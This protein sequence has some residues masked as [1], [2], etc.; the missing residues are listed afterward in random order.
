[1]RYAPALT[2]VFTVAASEPSA[3]ASQEGHLFRDRF[4]PTAAEAV[5]LVREHRTN[6]YVTVARTLT[7]AERVRRGIFRVDRIWAE[8]RADEPFMRV[9]ICYWLRALVQEAQ[10]TC[11]IE[12]LATAN[13]SSVALAE[14]LD[15]MSRDLQLSREQFVKA[16]DHEVAIAGSPTGKALHDTFGRLNPYD[17]R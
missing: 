3:A 8:R 15:G 5:R 7:Y 9:H 2:L 6:G 14:P 11:R 12:Y 13:P 1:M 4:V 16:I 10:S 17:W